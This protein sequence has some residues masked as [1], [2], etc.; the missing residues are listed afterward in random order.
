MNQSRIVRKSRLCG[1]LSALFRRL[2][3]LICSC[4][5]PHFSSVLFAS[6]CPTVN[7]TFQSG[8]ESGLERDQSGAAQTQQ[9]IPLP[10]LQT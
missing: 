4:A 6:M 7:L 3:Y 2:S 8:V 5:L 9:H 10:E 1:L